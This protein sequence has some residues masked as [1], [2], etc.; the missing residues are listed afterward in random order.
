MHPTAT[1]KTRA[2]QY[3]LRVILFGTYTSLFINAGSNKVSDFC[4]LFDSFKGYVCFNKVNGSV[5]ARLTIYHHSTSFYFPGL[6]SRCAISKEV[7]FPIIF[8]NNILVR[9]Q[10]N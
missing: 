1:K 2:L 5:C 7:D 3:Y 9:S 8:F 10:F 6:S 4:S